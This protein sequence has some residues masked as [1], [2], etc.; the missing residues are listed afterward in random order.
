MINYCRRGLKANK[1]DFFM[2]AALASSSISAGS[3][4][5]LLIAISSFSFWISHSFRFTGISKAYSLF[6]RLLLRPIYG[7]KYN[8][9][10]VSPYI[11]AT[12]DIKSKLSRSFTLILVNKTITVIML[13]ISNKPLA[14][15]ISRNAYQEFNFARIEYLNVIPEG[16]ESTLF[17]TLEYS[18][19]RRVSPVQWIPQ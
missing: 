6:I 15:I 11:I 10:W 19:P 4:P 9:P 14:Y 13:K 3:R 7:K 1:L 5:G 2:T 8:Y 18:A 16:D 17:Q 12:F